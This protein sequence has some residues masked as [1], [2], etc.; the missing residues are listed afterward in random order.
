[1]SS[2]SSNQSVVRDRADFEKVYSSGHKD[3]ESPGEERSSSS[4]SSSS[5]NK[6]MEMAEQEEVSDDSKEQALKSIVGADGLREFVMLLEWTV[7]DFNSTIKE[8]HFNTL[9]D[10]FQIP[11]NIPI[12]L[13]YKS[14]K[15]YYEGVEGVGVY[16][17]MLKAGLRFPLSSLHHELLKYLG[18]SVNQVSP[19]AWRVFIVMEVLYGAIIDGYRRLMV[20]EFLH[21]Y[22][23]DEIDK[24]RG[25]YSFVPRSLL[26]KVIFE[27]PDSNRD[28]KSR[29]FFLEGD[30]WICRPGDTEHMPVDTT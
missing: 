28:W 4:S 15:C 3:Q 25:M 26:L 10:N 11:D 13:P 2:V 5:T 12:C 6:D 14:E 29:Y 18:L 1:M 20:K 30:E 22:H 9:R 21:C 24:S 23:P 27:I 19:N 8:K 16:E 17:Q 7:N